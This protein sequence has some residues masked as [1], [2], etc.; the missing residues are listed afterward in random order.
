MYRHLAI[1]SHVP[2][3]L[4]FTTFML[5]TVDLSPEYCQ[6]FTPVICLFRDYVVH[7]SAT[8][9]QEGTKYLNGDRGP[10]LIQQLPENEEGYG[11][12][13]LPKKDQVCNVANIL[14]SYESCGNSI[15]LQ[16]LTKVFLSICSVGLYCILLKS[17]S[18]SY[19]T[20]SRISGKNGLSVAIKREK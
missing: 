12:R 8:C 9:L 16:K 4:P 2:N 5:Y 14:L 7:K 18:S 1:C 17:L 6:K 11:G 10:C 3:F 13:C 15:L 19:I 20:A